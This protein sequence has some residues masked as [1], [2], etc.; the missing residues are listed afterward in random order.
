MGQRK[1]TPT[2][3]KIK[4]R[5]LL[6]LDLRKQGGTYAEIAETLRQRDDIPD[7]YSQSSAYRDVHDEL[8]LLAQEC[9]EQAHEIRLIELTRID[10]MHSS[11][12]PYAREGDHQAIMLVMRLQDQR[13]KYAIGV[14]EKNQPQRG[15]SV[16]VGV[17]SATNT[18]MPGIR[19]VV[20][21]ILPEYADRESIAPIHH[22]D[23]VMPNAPE[24]GSEPEQP[25]SA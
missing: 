7:T 16:N 19:E 17:T 25:N 12:W 8:Q 24:P 20:V 9:A 2:K 11:V 15:S 14:V 1:T 5:R 13:A 4:E 21:E 23:V 3:I 6:A 22:T 18:G 10:E